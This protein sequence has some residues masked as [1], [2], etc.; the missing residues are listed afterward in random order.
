MITLHI[1]EYLFPSP[2]EGGRNMAADRALVWC[3]TAL[4]LMTSQRLAFAFDFRDLCSQTSMGRTIGL[5]TLCSAIGSPQGKCREIL[6]SRELY[7]G[8]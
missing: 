5:F 2:E 8:A 7:V 4:T 6:I 3:L 1:N